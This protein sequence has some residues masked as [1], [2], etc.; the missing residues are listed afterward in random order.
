MKKYYKIIYFII[1]AINAISSIVLLC[2]IC[3]RINNL[4]FDYIGIIVTILALLVTLLIG[5]NIFTALDFRKEVFSKIEECRKQRQHDLRLHSEL[6]N[7]E[8]ETIA[9]TLKRTEEYCDKLDNALYM[10]LSGKKEN[11]QN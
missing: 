2:I 7:R 6:N 9:R 11:E 4:G 10:H 1:S 8:F 3:P 5:W